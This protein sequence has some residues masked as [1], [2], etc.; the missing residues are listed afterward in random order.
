M[1]HLVF[2]LAFLLTL[3]HACEQGEIDV[4]EFN[5]DRGE[6]CEFC[7]SSS[8]ACDECTVRNGD[9]VCLVCKEGFYMEEGDEEYSCKVCAENCTHCIGINFIFPI[10]IL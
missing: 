7:F 8:D 1:K 6:S 2:T 3:S 9:V 5:S 4:N 10:I